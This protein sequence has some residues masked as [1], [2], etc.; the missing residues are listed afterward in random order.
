[1]AQRQVQGFNLT[2]GNRQAYEQDADR[3]SA[4]LVNGQIVEGFQGSEVKR[5][6]ESAQAKCSECE[7]EEKQLMGKAVS[8]ESESFIDGSKTSREQEKL[9][10]Q[11]YG[12]D[13]G[14]IS[15]EHPGFPEPKYTRGGSLP[16]YPRLDPINSWTNYKVAHFYQGNIQTNPC[17]FRGKLWAVVQIWQCQGDWI[18]NVDCFNSPTIAAV[19]FNYEEVGVRPRNSQG[20][21]CQRSLQTQIRNKL[22]TIQVESPQIDFWTILGRLADIVTILKA[23]QDA[24]PQEE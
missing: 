7:Q 6:G 22:E 18:L 9:M 4:R 8:D 15:L 2:E 17:C 20:V 11:G 23:F 12:C 13:A 10:A 21:D 14:S 16:G 3:I 1:V 24:L 19:T 5:N